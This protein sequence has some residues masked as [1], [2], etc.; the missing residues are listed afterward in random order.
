MNIRQWESCVQSG[1]CV[2]S[3]SIKNNVSTI[4]S[5]VCNCFNATKSFCINMWRWMKHGSTTSLWSQISSQLSGQQQ[6]KAIQTEQR[7][8]HQ[9]VKFWPPYF[10]MHKVFC[11]SITLK[12]EKLSI[13]NIWPSVCDLGSIPGRV[14]PKTLKMV[15]DT[16]LLNTRQYK[17]CIK[18]KGE[19]SRERSST[20]V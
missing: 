14:I 10:R 17:V 18:G 1:C 2:C 20:S 6:V 12:K 7:H 15:L 3:Q 4:Q 9:Q 5:I 13:V 19:Q 8:K 11:S 16:T